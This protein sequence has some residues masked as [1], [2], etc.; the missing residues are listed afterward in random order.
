MCRSSNR[1]QN[2][3]LKLFGLFLLVSSEYSLT[4]DTD[5]DGLSDDW[6][7]A[8]GRNPLVADYLITAGGK[9][10]CALDDNGAVCW[11][12]SVNDRTAVPALI[13]PSSIT[14]G[15]NH[16][17][18]LDDSRV[19]CWGRNEAGQASVPALSNPIQVTAGG[20]H[21]CAIDDTGVICWGDNRKGET[22]VPPLS[23]PFQVRAGGDHACAIDK[24]GVVCWG[25]NVYGQATV[26]I[27]SSPKQPPKKSRNRNS[28]RTIVRTHQTNTVRII[29]LPFEGWQRIKG[30][31]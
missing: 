5:N 17:C 8:N 24:S 15:E 11:G 3:F 9:H 25:D 21:T 18:A 14:A 19:V 16:T 13:N 29:F 7:I 10:T 27:L 4:L 20:D 2:S 6:E 1:G 28:S 31:I 23:D 12:Y 22:I 30:F 26:P